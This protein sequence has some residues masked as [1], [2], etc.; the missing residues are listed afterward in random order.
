MKFRP[1][2][3]CPTAVLC[4][5]ACLSATANAEQPYLFELLGKPAY[6]KSWNTLFAGERDVDRWLA[7]YAKTKNGPATPGKSVQLGGTTYQINMVCKTHEC[8]SNQFFVLFSPDGRK[9]WGLLLKDGNTERFF[10]QPDDEKKAA[11][12][13]EAQE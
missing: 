11:L 10:G 3:L 6:S 13:A 5:L 7:R 9:A 4:A 1:G 2:M 8:G 12:R